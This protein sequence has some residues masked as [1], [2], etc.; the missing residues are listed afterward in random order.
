MIFF[1]VLMGIN[2][3]LCM[4]NICTDRARRL[5][6]PVKDTIYFKHLSRNQPPINYGEVLGFPVYKNWKITKEKLQT[7]WSYVLFETRNINT[8]TF[9]MNVQVV[10]N[11]K[12][13]RDT[14]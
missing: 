10:K 5:L 9:I 13:V 1:K 6:W 7:R 4:L 11:D 2:L 12:I 3:K 8:M 14:D